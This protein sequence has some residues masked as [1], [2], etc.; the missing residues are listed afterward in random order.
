MLRSIE[1]ALPGAQVDEHDDEE[2]LMMHWLEDCLEN[3]EAC[4]NNQR[5]YSPTR[6]LDVD[7]YRSSGDIVLVETEAD[8]LPLYHI[9]PLLG[10]AIERSVDYDPRELTLPT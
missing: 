2:R 6:L 5:G 3:H 10:S 7:Q 9:E 1:H 8:P 4:R